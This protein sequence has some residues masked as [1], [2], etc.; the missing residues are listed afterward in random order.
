MNRRR[1]LQA[2]G[3]LAVGAAIP[4]VDV[5]A[6]LTLADLRAATA[7]LRRNAAPEHY[8]AAVHPDLYADFVSITRRGQWA[9]AYRAWRKDGKPGGDA[10]QAIWAAYGRTLDDM[11]LTGEIGSIETFRFIESESFA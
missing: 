5:P 6:G 9:D 7:I 1:F 3:V 8:Y 2:A 10:P 11:P 4:A